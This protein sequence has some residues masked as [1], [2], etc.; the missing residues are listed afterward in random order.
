MWRKW[1]LAVCGSL[2][3]LWAALAIYAYWPTGENLPVEALATAE[4]RFADVETVRIRYRRYGLTGADRPQLILLHGFA[5]SLQTWRLVAPALAACCD[6]IALDLP[7]FGLSDKPVDFDYHND[8]Q[9]RRVVAFA[10][11]LDLRAPIYVGHSL[12]GAIA[13][14]AAVIDPAA[15]GLVLLNPGILSTGVPKIVQVTVPPLPRLS[16]RLFA[17]RDFRR[18]F[19]RRSYVNPALVTDE[20]VDAVMLGARSA[21]YLPGMTSMMRQYREG[22]EI[23][24]AR[25]VTVPTLILWGDQD[26]NKPRDE[27]DR[28]RSLIGR[29]QL[30]RFAGAGHYVHEEAPAEVAAALGE[31]L[32]AMSPPA[33]MVASTTDDTRL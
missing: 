16:A 30:V 8:A 15:R 3:L 32:R 6:V 9:A 10:R 24:L 22:D 4:D 18:N 5:N 12:G 33:N 25:R 19:L 11:A 31:W 2:L 21:G 13:L 28:L 23:P 1:L 20:V 17:D 14:Q 26:R 27:A 7:G 29:A